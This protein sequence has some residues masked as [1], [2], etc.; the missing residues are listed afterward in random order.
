MQN[1]SLLLVEKERLE[2]LLEYGILDTPPDEEF[3]CIVRLTASICEVPLA[4]ISFVDS[5]RQWFKSRLGFDIP[6]TARR[7]AFCSHTVLENELLIIN[8][9]FDHF[10]LKNSPFVSGEPGIR[11][12]AGV[13]LRSHRGNAIGALCTMDTRPRNLNHYQQNSLK[14]LGEQVERILENR[15]IRAKW[16]TTM[17]IQRRLLDMLIKDVNS[18]LSAIG[19]FLNLID[20]PE[21]A[22]VTCSEFT[23]MATEQFHRT[24]AVLNSL[25]EWG[26][27]YDSEPTRKRASEAPREFIQQLLERLQKNPATKRFSIVNKIKTSPQHSLPEPELHFI[28]KCV[29]L[30]FCEV[31]N[32]GTI[33]INELNH[34]KDILHAELQIRSSSF[35][36]KLNGKIAKLAE[37]Q[38]WPGNPNC[39]SD[40]FFISLASDIVQKFNGNLLLELSPNKLLAKFHLDMSR[41]KPSNTL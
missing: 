2:D 24:T 26:K 6:E 32:E 41:W 28:L 31:A 13:P 30:W 3:D 22:V 34:E 33:I 19:T 16:R 40:G 27:L 18:P 35:I 23:S 7:D 39:P 10:L 1:V 20:K 12:Y 25:V 29:I 37:T 21:K 5:S 8:D 4:A 14:V 38:S 11:F 15:R 36:P 9:A 17:D